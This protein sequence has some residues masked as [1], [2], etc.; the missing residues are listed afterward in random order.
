MSMSTRQ[1]ILIV[2]DM[3]ANIAVLVKALTSD[4]EISVAV[5]GEDALS[6]AA[7]EHAPDLILLDIMMPGVDGYEVCRRL[8]KDAATREIPV[9]F[10]TAKDAEK[11]ETRGLE[12]GAVDY[13]TKPF[14]LPIVKARVKTHLELKRKSDLLE[15]LASLDGLTCIANRRRFDQLL[16]AEWS[17]ALRTASWISIIML[18]IDF[19]KAFNDNYG[20]AAGDDCLRK[21]AEALEGSLRRSA[22]TVARYG[23][24]E[25]VAILPGTEPDGASTVAETL[26]QAVELL[27]IAHAYSAVSQVVTVSAGVASA[28]PMA[29]SSA[30]TLVACADKRLYEAKFEGRNRVKS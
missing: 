8:K 26:R 15:N 2:D 14:S 19:F 11:D 10:I 1:K 23:G 13:I 27:A 30:G 16:E 17:R 24:E 4:Y 6:I 5:D 21:V 29:D 7:S 25:F 9:I 18:D 20:H 12:L 3:P 22:D 28:I